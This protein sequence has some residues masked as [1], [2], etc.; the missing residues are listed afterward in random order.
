MKPPIDS[1]AW[2]VA[3]LLFSMALA[4]FFFSRP[5]GAVGLFPM[6]L[7]LAFFRDPKRKIPPGD[8]PVSPAD[9]TVV[10]VSSVFDG[11][12]LKE[13]AVKIGIFLSLFVPHVNRAPIPGMVNYLRYEP[14]QRLNAL[15]KESVNQNESNWIGIGEGSHR[16]LVRQIAG[17]IARRIHCDVQLE[18]KVERGEKVGIIC[19]GSRAE[20]YF[21]RNRF[22]PGIQLGQ[23]V[24]AGQTVLGEWL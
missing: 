2:P 23:K 18:K 22:R 6:G 14:G 9:G 15:R 11:R 17:A 3:A 21:P 4:L 16:V 13:E 19:Y 7:H 8:G 10:E 1:R 24:K 12:F 5:A 20:C